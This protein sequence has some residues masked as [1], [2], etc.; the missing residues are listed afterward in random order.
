MTSVVEKLSL[1]YLVDER[2]RSM[3]SD[4]GGYSDDRGGGSRPPNIMD[5]RKQLLGEI[6][7]WSFSLTNKPAVR[8]RYVNT[9]SSNELSLLLLEFLTCYQRVV[10]FPLVLHSSL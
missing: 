8:M 3:Y 10:V 9:I 1:D 7:G 2:R 6:G 5:I 4:C